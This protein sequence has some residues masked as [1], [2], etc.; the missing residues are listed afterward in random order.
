MAEPA[1][2]EF[3]QALTASQ[4]RLYGYVFSLVG[5]HH[6]AADV[7]QETNLVLWRKVDEFRVGS[8]FL[9]WAF[10][11]ARFQVLAH[12]RDA[13]R[14]R[15]VLGPEL[16]EL[17]SDEVETSAGQIEDMRVALRGCLSK[18]PPAS[19]NLV[20]LRYFAGRS[21]K[22]LADELNKSSSATKVALLRVRA[23]LRDC[24][25]R[26]LGGAS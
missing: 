16:I 14:E 10:A 11:I 12:F 4:S 20:Q 5:D 6:K 18:L 1:H 15:T 25:Q 3:V 24:V 21:I 9:P 22:Q 8:D 17:M 7:L 23:A 2:T 13:G 26:E 19:H